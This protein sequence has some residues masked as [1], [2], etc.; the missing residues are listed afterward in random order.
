MPW[1][2]LIPCLLAAILIPRALAKGR[3]A[4]AEDWATLP[5]RDPEDWEP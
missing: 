1:L 4:V 5:A 3:K 2:L